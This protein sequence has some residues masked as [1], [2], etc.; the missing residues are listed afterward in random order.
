MSPQKVICIWRGL[1]WVNPASISKIT[2][3]TKFLVA[4]FRVNQQ[5]KSEAE[6]PLDKVIAVLILTHFVST[7]GLYALGEGKHLDILPKGPIENY[8]SES[9]MIG[10]KNVLDK[11]HQPL[12]GMYNKGCVREEWLQVVTTISVAQRKV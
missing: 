2:V 4:V 1:F 10:R 7:K 11:H 3:E 12:E 6:S 8:L 9:T 5:N